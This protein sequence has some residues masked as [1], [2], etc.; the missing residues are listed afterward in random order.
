MAFDYPAGEALIETIIKDLDNF[1]G[2]NTGREDWLPKLTSGESGYYAILRPGPFE[3]RFDGPTNAVALWTTV[4]EI[5]QRFDAD[6][7]QTNVT[8]LGDRRNEIVDRILAKKRLSD[9]TN[10]IRDSNV[11]GG[12]DVEEVDIA[13]SRRKS[14]KWLRAT[15]NVQWEEEETI[16]YS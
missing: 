1:G 9:T 6:T 11:T 7:H 12:D 5:Y 16:T 3:L 2:H 8:N 4:V 15:V 10:T 13:I 14:T